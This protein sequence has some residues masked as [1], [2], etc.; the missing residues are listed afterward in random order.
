MIGARVIQAGLSLSC[1]RRRQLLHF[2]MEDQNTCTE[3]EDIHVGGHFIRSSH[4]FKVTVILYF[5]LWIMGGTMP[6]FSE[7]DNPA[8]FSPYILTRSVDVHHANFI[9]Y[10]VVLLNIFIAVK[11]FVQ[12]NRSHCTEIIHS[13]S[14][15]IILNHRPAMHFEEILIMD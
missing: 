11:S 3:M 15:P 9:W 5:R 1:K 2:L 14:C 6:L 7:Q 12:N 4:S 10:L 13:G 8:S